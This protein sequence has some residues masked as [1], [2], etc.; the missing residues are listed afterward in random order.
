MSAGILLKVKGLPRDTI[1]RLEI[2]RDGENA[3]TGD[4]SI[5][6]ITRTFEELAGF[7]FRECSFPF[8]A[9]LMTGTGI[10]PEF[11]FTLQ[12]GDV[13]SICIEHIGTLTNT[14]A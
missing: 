4:V 7:L 6:M 3:F 1:I 11:P 10:V 8:G 12:R 5:T 14:V 13:I 2:A 9:V